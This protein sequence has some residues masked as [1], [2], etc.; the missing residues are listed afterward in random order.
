MIKHWGFC[1]RV[2]NRDAIMSTEVEIPIHEF[3][4]ILYRRDIPHPGE[5]VVGR[6]VDIQDHGLYIHL[7]EYGKTAYVPLR[8]L[9]WGIVR[10]LR[11]YYKLEQIVVARVIKVGKGGYIDASLRRLSKKESQSKLSYWRKLNRSIRLALLISSKIGLDW[12]S[13]VEK[14][15]V[16]LMNCYETPFDGMEDAVIRGKQILEEC[17]VPPEYVDIVFKTASESISIRRQKMKFLLDISTLAPDGVIRIRNALL[18]A[19]KDFKNVEVKYES[20]PR[21]AIWVEGFEK[22]EIRNTAM[23]FAKKVESLLASM[24][25]A[26]KYKTTVNIIQT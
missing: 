15:Y 11:Q 16:P 22:T 10:S 18:E 7:P 5:I 14:I 3:C 4:S 19:L 17:G 21:Y 13:V 23:E 25:D 1:I 8:E 24:P 12:K 2:N 20:A 9:E 26:K 6:V